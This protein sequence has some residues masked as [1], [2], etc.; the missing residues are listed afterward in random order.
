MNT[1]WK[2]RG[3]LINYAISRVA[4]KPSLDKEGTGKCSSSGNEWTTKAQLGVE[5]RGM[6]VLSCT[7]QYERR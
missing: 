3:G 6:G 5:E 4:F 7:P 1:G 2:K